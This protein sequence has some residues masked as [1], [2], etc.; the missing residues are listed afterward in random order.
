MIDIE[1]DP[2]KLISVFP[3]IILGS[4]LLEVITSNLPA[5]REI[6]TDNVDSI[7]CDPNNLNHWKNAITKLNKDT[8]FKGIYV[9]S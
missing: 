6:L 3:E 8:A 9:P 7:L 5:I 1:E 2:R 4:F